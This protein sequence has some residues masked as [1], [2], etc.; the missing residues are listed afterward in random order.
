VLQL[1]IL[2]LQGTFAG[3]VLPHPLRLRLW[4]RD[5]L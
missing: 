2:T 3:A 4:R 5:V 1:C